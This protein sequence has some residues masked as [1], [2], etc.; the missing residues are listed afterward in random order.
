[1][2]QVI[3]AVPTIN[4]LLV[5]MDVARDFSEHAVFAVK[6]LHHDLKH[7]EEIRLKEARAFWMPIFGPGS[8]D[9]NPKH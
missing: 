7:R 9:G 3:E 5:L 6:G 4:D 1:M 2:D 8:G